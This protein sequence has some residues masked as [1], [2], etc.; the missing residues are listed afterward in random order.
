MQ[1]IRTNVVRRRNSGKPG[2][3]L[4]SDREIMQEEFFKPKHM[5]V[6]AAVLLSGTGSNAE[7]LI[8]HCRRQTHGSFEITLLVTDAPETSRARELAAESGIELLEWDI[9]RFYREQG[10]ESIRLDSPRRRELREAW[11]EE[12]FRR[13]VPHEI[14]FGLLAGFVPLTNLTAKLP[15]LNV[16]PGDLTVEEP[17]GKRRYAGL[18]VLPVEKALCDGNAYLRSSVILA[19]TYTGSGGKEMDSGPV[20]GVSA[21]VPVDSEGLSAAELIEIRARRI[22]GVPVD[23]ALRTLAKTHLERLKF[24][25]DHVVFPRAAEDF[26]AGC[27]AWKGGRVRFDS[28]NGF[29]SVLTV[30]YSPAGR[31]ILK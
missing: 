23:D 16:H 6:R 2:G 14:D 27:F 29:E 30:E 31:R 7:A 25:G 28:G 20:I 22:P 21:P 8:R 11:S 12:L 13:I 18:H 10:E 19:Q 1:I 26:A 9:R 5:P 17:D 15:C 24:A 4:F 3:D